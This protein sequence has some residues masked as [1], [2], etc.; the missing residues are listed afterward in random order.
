MQEDSPG[1]LLVPPSPVID[2]IRCKSIRMRF[3]GAC[4]EPRPVR[5]EALGLPPGK[6]S[7]PGSADSMVKKAPWPAAEM[8]TTAGV[9]DLIPATELQLRV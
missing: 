4:W 7:Q 5:K 3:R 6:E 2:T 8:R 1:H 9:A